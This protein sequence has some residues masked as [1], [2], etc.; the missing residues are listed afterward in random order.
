MRILTGK[1]DAFDEALSMQMLQ[2]PPPSPTPAHSVF[3]L[4]SRK[5]NLTGDPQRAGRPPTTSQVLHAELLRLGH[6]GKLIVVGAE[7]VRE[8][9]IQTAKAR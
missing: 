5:A 4:I 1:A 8:Q 6:Y 7:H 9:Q 2:V 3:P